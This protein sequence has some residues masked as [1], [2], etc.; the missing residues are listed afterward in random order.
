MKINE[1][2]IIEKK[3][4]RFCIKDIMVKEAEEEIE[5]EENKLRQ[6]E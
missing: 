1:K 4:L 6:Q 2:G 5:V 3:M